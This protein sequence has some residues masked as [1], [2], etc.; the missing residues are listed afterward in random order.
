[1]DAESGLVHTVETT[2][3]NVH[4]SSMT[5][6]LLRGEET[7]VYGDS[8]YLGSENKEDAVRVNRNGE[9]AQYHINLRASQMKKV[10]GARYDAVQAQEHA[11][12]S[13]RCKAGHVFRGVKLIFLFRKT[14]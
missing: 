10:P 6:S 2:A 5:S 14:R 8:G 1:M 4:D 13:M 12:S 11:K 7:D 9:S 3:A